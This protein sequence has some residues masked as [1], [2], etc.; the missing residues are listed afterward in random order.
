[1]TLD[2]FVLP[3]I[4]RT[5]LEEV[6]LQ[7]KSLGLG[8]AKPFLSKVMNPPDEKAIDLALDMLKD[9]GALYIIEES[10]TPLGFHL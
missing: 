2:Q 10:L 9:I 6:I 3:E 5:R 4:L 1:M 7:I 8:L